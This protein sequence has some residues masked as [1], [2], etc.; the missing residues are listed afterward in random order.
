MWLMSSS[1]LISV[2][3][4]GA[5]TVVTDG[6]NNL[7]SVVDTELA[8]DLA[9]MKLH[10]RFRHVEFAADDLVGVALTKTGENGVLPLG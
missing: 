10:C 4:F 5:E 1:G 7:R 6:N 9:D 8:H 2:S 3:R